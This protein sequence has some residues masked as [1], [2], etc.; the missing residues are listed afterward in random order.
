MATGRSIDAEEE[1]RRIVNDARLRPQEEKEL[2]E[3]LNA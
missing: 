1:R 2:E 3:F